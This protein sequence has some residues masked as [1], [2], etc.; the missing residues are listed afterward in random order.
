[1][2]ESLPP[3]SP[4]TAFFID[5]DGTLVDIAP[6]PELV[7]VEPRVIDLLGALA[8]R[9]DHAVAVVTGRSLD[10]VDGFLAPL[11]LPAAAEHGSIRRDASGR[12]HEDVRTIHA[13]ELAAGRLQPLVEANPGLLLERKQAS[14]ALHFRQ[15][16]ELAE[17]C[18]EAVAQ[19]VD[20]AEGIVVLP[21]KMI[22]EL[23]PQGIDKGVAVSA[24][25]AEAPFKG[26]VPVYMGDDVTDEH[27]FAVVNERGGISIKIDD[28][29]TL[30]QYRTDRA[31]L[32]AWLSGLAE[33]A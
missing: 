5:F 9:F 13:I 25:L 31:G 26:R 23:R 16:P 4:N 15:R 2:T 12:V 18:R 10:V 7:E 6:R 14:V 21:G 19:A 32:F 17:T 30:A 11:K 27:A 20:G 24:F 33:T 8:G 1:M 22:F 3:V 28:G 29:D